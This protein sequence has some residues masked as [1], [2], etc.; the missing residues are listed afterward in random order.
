MSSTGTT[1]PATLPGLDV[2]HHQGSVNWH[3]VAEAGVSFAFAKATDGDTFVDPQ[4]DSNWIGMK[5]SGIAR[6][7]Y[8][9]FRPTRPVD[10]QVDNFVRTVGE[11]GDGDLPPVLD[12]EE[13]PTPHGDSWEDIPGDERVPMV[14]NW[15]QSIEAKLGRKP[16]IY[17]RRGFVSL[18]LPNATPLGS[19]LVWIAHY[20]TKPSPAFP[21]IWSNWSFWQ[22]SEAGKV[23]GIAGPVDLDRFNGSATDLEKLI[24]TGNG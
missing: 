13:A 10:A 15:L 4:F 17:T 5:N 16:I 6:G 22:Y 21:D 3:V 9:F 19:Y 20:T 23:D 7:A 1:V 11:I 24:R 18:E 8:H 12:T 14:I 2:S